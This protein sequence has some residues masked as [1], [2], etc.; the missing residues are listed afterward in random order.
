VTILRN[1]AKCVHCNEEIESV[2]RHD[3]NVH[4][5]KV[6]PAQRRKWEG[7]VI[8]DVPGETTWSFAVDGGTD[9]LKRTG[10]RGSYVDTSEV[11]E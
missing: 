11:T 6:K 5:C 10:E 4:Y 8:V 1:S 2:H 3:F 7:D 9:Y